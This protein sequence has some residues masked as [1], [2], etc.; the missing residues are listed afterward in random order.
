VTEKEVEAAEEKI[1]KGQEAEG[2]RKLDQQES[3]DMGRT[4]GEYC[5]NTRNETK[6]REEG[7]RSIDE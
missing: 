5:S 6:K 7:N 3:A 4:A 1:S 2:N